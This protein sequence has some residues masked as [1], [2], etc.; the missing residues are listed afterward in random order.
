MDA[1]AAAS[2]GRA[3]TR[4]FQPLTSE[5][6]NNPYETY[7]RMRAET[8]VAW[9][10][11]PL[12]GFLGFWF[13]TRYDDV[14]SV[15]KDPRL[16]RDRRQV[17]PPEAFPPVAAEHRPFAE[18]LA[19]W[20]S[21]QDPPEHTRLRSTIA[22]SFTPSMVQPRQMRMAEIANALLDRVRDTDGMDIIDDFAFPY[23]VT[24][25]A[26]ILGVPPDD[27]PLFHRWTHQM[28]AAMDMNRTSASIAT[29][30]KAALELHD[31]FRLL[32]N[33]RRRRP[34]MDLISS[35]V[36]PQAE[37]SWRSEHELTSMC[38][39]LL[40]AGCETTRNFLGNSVLSLLR[41]PKELQTLRAQPEILPTAFE[42][43]LRFESPTQMVFCYA[44]EDLEIRGQPI[45]KGQAV[46]CG[47]GAANR[48][49]EQFADPDRLN[50]KR[51][52]NKHVAF[53]AGRHLCAGAYLARVEGQVALQAL[54]TRLPGLELTCSHP[55][56][57]EA[58][59]LRSLRHL[60]V[61]WRHPGRTSQ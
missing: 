26:E 55:D 2:E 48:D 49:P 40:I 11:A 39:F 52:D 3:P 61:C 31:Y 60:P 6:R 10:T 24:V 27:A 44:L 58:I 50:L 46:G 51:A 16:G 8:P 4:G 30:S 5:F 23:P 33:E 56:W 13:L 38:I 25:F 57:D 14:V 19:S 7:R 43:L 17:L 34:R 54:L 47:L 20:L 45:R 36:V 21:F 1:R 22:R 15:L 42:E 9:G 41:Y 59:M 35:L 53:G 18:T 12:P 37:G 29:G 28:L 32:A